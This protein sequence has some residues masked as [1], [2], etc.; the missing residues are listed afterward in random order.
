M[1]NA[2][3]QAAAQKIQWQPGETTGDRTLSSMGISANS[4]GKTSSHIS[5]AKT[6]SQ[7]RG[8]G[9]GGGQRPCPTEILH[10]PTRNR[11]ASALRAPPGAGS[12]TGQ[13]SSSGDSQE[14]GEE[15]TYT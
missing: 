3:S 7:L 14:K 1:W 4:F 5:N 8:R 9:V 15:K 10:K 2:L 11:H 13:P 12:N 6:E